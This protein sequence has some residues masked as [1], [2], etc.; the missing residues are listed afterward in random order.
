M[1]ECGVSTM[2]IAPAFDV[3]EEDQARVRVEP[4]PQPISSG[5]NSQGSTI[6][7]VKRIPVNAC[8]FETLE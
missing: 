6:R 1:P 2:R 4:K 3:A 7:R 5:C 8:R